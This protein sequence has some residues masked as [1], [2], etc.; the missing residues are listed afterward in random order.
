MMEAMMGIKSTP[1]QGARSLT[2][3]SRCERLRF[4]P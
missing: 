3:T 1:A 4:V 2:L